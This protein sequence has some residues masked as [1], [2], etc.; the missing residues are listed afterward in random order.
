MT[1]VIDVALSGYYAPTNN[2]KGLTGQVW[3]NQ[4]GLT[5]IAVLP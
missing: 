1:D 5:R 3:P 4:G 2:V